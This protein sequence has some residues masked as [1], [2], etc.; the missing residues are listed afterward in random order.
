MTD[1]T[2]LRYQLDLL[3]LG[4]GT[5]AA[6]MPIL[7]DL[8]R[9]LR[10]RLA[11]PDLTNYGKARLNALL[12]ESRKIISDY[13]GQAQAELFPVLEGVA[14]S[15]ATMTAA[16]IGTGAAVAPA[17]YLASLAANSL[18]QGATQ[19]AWWAKQSGDL[20][21][22]FN[23][24]VRTGLAA[25]DTNAQIIRTVADQFTMAR[26]S[27]AALVQ[28]GVQT[29][30]N[31][32]RLAV[33]EANSDVVLALRELE[34]LDSRTCLVCA[35]RDRKTWET[36]SKAP[37]GHSIPFRNTPIHWNCRGAIVPVTKAE[38]APGGARA[39]QAGPVARNTSFADFL[40]RQ[41]EAFQVD[42]LGKGRAEMYRAGK[43]TLDDLVSGTGRP[44]T[45][46]QL[47][48]IHG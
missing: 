20:A 11:D 46:D 22:R 15:S 43:I 25:G 37:I 18:T 14:Q 44:L 29:V 40:D 31:D 41:G 19:A 33:F 7:R 1:D 2:F 8:E 26:R 6:I 5:V 23:A 17:P 13:Y 30:A 9:E 32:A 28:T 10:G 45:L 34:T 42:V 39:S 4:A 38:N 24:L 21:F 27:A 35:S 36:V 47:R 16:T 3:R 12:A 48:A